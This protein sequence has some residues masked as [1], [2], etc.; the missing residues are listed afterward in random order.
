VQDRLD[1]PVHTGPSL[2]AFFLAAA[3]A[4]PLWARAAGHFGAK[5][6]LLAAMAAAI[7]IF[8]CALTLGAGDWFGFYLVAIGSGAAMGADLTLLPAMVSQRLAV[9]R[10]AGEATFGLWGFVNKAGLALAAGLAL[11]ALDLVGFTPGAANSS[12]ALAMLSFAYAGVPCL[13]KAIALA[14]L[15]MTP[16][17]EPEIVR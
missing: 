3:F 2:V 12:S 7:L 1:A 14:T 17:T 11:P 15:A 8:A 16:V 4:A 13:L 10:Q 6:T 5:K 9:L